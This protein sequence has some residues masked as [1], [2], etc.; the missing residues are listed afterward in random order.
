MPAFAITFGLAGAAM[1]VFFGTPRHATVA[2]NSNA[3]P[4]RFARTVPLRLRA[5]PAGPVWLVKNTPQFDLYSNGLRI[6][7]QYATAT[8]PRHYL[9]FARTGSRLDAAQWRREPEGIVFHTTESHI[10]PFEEDQ[11]Q[12]LQRAGEGLLEYV[13]RTRAYHFVI[14]RFGRVFRVV[15]ESDYA[16][17]AGNSIWADNSWIYI[18]LNESF[19]GIAFEARS[20]AAGA[21]L[22]VTAAQ[23]HSG[24]ILTEMLRARYGIPAANCVTHAQVSVNPGNWEAGYHL[25]W[26]ANLPFGDLGLANNYGRALPS[27]TLFGF[28]ADAALIDK[29]GPPFAQGIDAAEQQVQ[30]DAGAE[31]QPVE[32][33]R[34]TLQKRYRDAIRALRGS[35]A[36]QFTTN[37]DNNQ[38]PQTRSTTHE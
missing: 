10:A 21:G 7:N 28:R 12:V 3:R 33:Y 29:A 2:A 37:Q 23:V 5:E 1:L 25:D 22:P 15:R 26:A 34:K 4:E 24:R 6:E 31:G 20:G 16:N 36:R 19:F 35:D 27:M 8:E 11:N 9:A 18:N 32:L 14:D 13:N 17:H 30:R 38:R